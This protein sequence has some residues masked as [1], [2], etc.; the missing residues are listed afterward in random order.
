MKRTNST[1]T[2]LQLAAA[3]SQAADL[4][5]CLSGFADEPT[6]SHPF[7]A[8]PKYPCS[9]PHLADQGGRSTHASMHLQILR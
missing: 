9:H 1:R 6:S 3:D 5:V 7:K 2:N 4:C 8:L